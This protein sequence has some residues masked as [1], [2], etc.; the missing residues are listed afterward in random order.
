MQGVSQSIIEQTG[1]YPYQRFGF[2]L[3]LHPLLEETV[4]DVKTSLWVLM[5]AVGFVLLRVCANVAGL[6]LVRS[7]ARQKEIAVRVALGAGIRRITRQLLT[8]SLLLSLL[9]GLLGLL[10]TPLLLRVIV[11]LSATALPRVVSTG[12]DLGPLLF[13]FPCAVRT[14]ILF[15]LAPALDASRG[16]QYQILTD[17]AL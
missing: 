7:T 10:L 11:T 17:G 1:E 9:G 16:V 8:G 2:A 14:A 4:G 12:V 6:L 15:G 13:T 3:I 5:G